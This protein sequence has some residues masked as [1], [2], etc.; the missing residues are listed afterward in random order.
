MEFSQNAL[1]QI[2]CQQLLEYV[3]LLEKRGRYWCFAQT[4]ERHVCKLTFGR[5]AEQGDCC[6]LDKRVRDL[7]Q[8]IRAEHCFK[9]IVS[10]NLDILQGTKPD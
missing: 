6:E 7:G 3:W 2:P 10:C 5:Q 8:D 9:I 1:Q 4:L